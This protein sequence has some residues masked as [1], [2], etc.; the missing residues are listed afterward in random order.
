MKIL[1]PIKYKELTYAYLDVSHSR[2]TSILES[3]MFL[4]DNLEFDKIYVFALTT[5]QTLTRNIDI[6]VTV[7]NLGVVEN[8]FY[9]HPILQNKVE[10]DFIELL[11]HL[12]FVVETP[13]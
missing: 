8:I 1:S 13:T 10:S 6:F 9:P 11:R 3:C 4:P 2:H 12:N 7:D 5:P